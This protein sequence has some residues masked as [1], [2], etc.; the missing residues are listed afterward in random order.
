[1]VTSPSLTLNWITRSVAGAILFHGPG[2]LLDRVTGRLLRLG[3]DPAPS[4]G[5]VTGRLVKPG[6]SLDLIHDLI[7]SSV[8]LLGANLLLQLE[9]VAGVGNSSLVLSL[10]LL[11]GAIAR[12]IRVRSG[13]I[14]A[15]GSHSYGCGAE[16][17][18]CRDSHH[19]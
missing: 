5:L 17:Q 15:P 6:S 7:A 1:V 14:P 16:H 18:R 3:L 11:S 19:R 12:A 4:H 2:T 9:H 8:L 13:T 10:Y